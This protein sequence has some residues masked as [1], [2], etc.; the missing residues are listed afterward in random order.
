MC[1]AS[2]TGLVD[3]A[4]VNRTSILAGLLTVDLSASLEGMHALGTQA[5]RSSLRGPQLHCTLP[6]VYVRAYQ[7]AVLR[8]TATEVMCAR[9]S[10]C[11]TR[12]SQG[13]RHHHSLSF[14]LTD[15]CTLLTPLVLRDTGV[16]VG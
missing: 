5:Q 6:G 15:S 9:A 4:V 12:Q 2:D 1:W 7:G 11:F 14:T 13:H 10:R 3:G 8:C 16:A